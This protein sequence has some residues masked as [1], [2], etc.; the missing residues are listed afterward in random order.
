MIINDEKGLPPNLIPV[1]RPPITP[2]VPPLNNQGPG[3][4]FAGA[5]PSTLQ[6]DSVFVR[7]QYPNSAGVP[8]FP[9]VPLSPANAV[10]NSAV[11]SATKQISDEAGE[12]AIL[13]DTANQNALKAL[14]ATFQGAWSN[15]IDYAQGALVD[16]NGVIWVSLQPY[17]SGHEPDLTSGVWWNSTGGTSTFEGDWNSATTYQVGNQVIDV[18]GGGGYY[19][20]LLANTNKQP[21]ANPT[22]W[23]LITAGNLNSY[24]GNYSGATSYT[25][26]E[27]V[28]YQGSLWICIAATSG[29]APSTISSFWTLLGSNGLF[30]GP[31]SS[32]TS[33]TQNMIV[34][35]QNNLWQAT[36]AS[37]NQTPTQGSSTYWILTGPAT[38]DN[39]EN[40]EIYIKGVGV[41]TA[42]SL[43]IQNSNFEASATVL[44][45]PGWVAYDGGTIG[46]ITSGQQSGTQSVSL[47]PNTLA[48]YVTTQQYSCQPGDQ[49]LVGGYCKT[50][51]TAVAEIAILFFT[52][53]GS[54]IAVSGANFGSPISWTFGSGTPIAPANAVYFQVA[55]RLQQASAGTAY[56]D[57]IFCYYLYPSSTLLNPQ[58]SIPPI[59]TPN[60][61]L[62]IAW[63]ATVVTSAPLLNITWSAFNIYYP[64]GL[65]ISV[66]AN[67]GYTTPS[68][69]SLTTVS[70]GSLALR[71]RYVRI[72]FIREG[73]I[74]AIGPETSIS[75]AASHLLQVTSPSAVAGYDGWMPIAAA[76]TLTESFINNSTFGSGGIGGITPIAFGTN[77][78]EPTAGLTT[79]GD[80]ISE[81]LATA[82]STGTGLFV[83]GNTAN[84]TTYSIYPAYNPTDGNLIFP[85]GILSS[86]GDAA[87][88]ALMW[89]DGNIP[90]Q[91][92]YAQT[93]SP[94][95]GGS[96]SG[97]G[98]G[99]RGVL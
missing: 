56:F 21:S 71:T 19:I 23:Q 72:C 70:G 37:T 10:Q 83:M 61:P 12:A 50:D 58:G 24:E 80:T 85:N 32:S 88:A 86:A 1:D 87:S 22:D 69:P 76:N 6:H 30:M 38:L 7:T 11:L 64:D 17:N 94:S 55:I 57:N 73:A 18:A 79:N 5:I 16:Y 13:A 20:A 78:T 89:A 43:T 33:Y 90:L 53:T 98:G 8:S 97:S 93:T 4:F 31:W 99:G 45:P 14:A 59:V 46:Y 81:Y 47:G 67:T 95:A 52:G 42:T 77:W 29:N 28:S 27:T 51:G 3:D 75:V 44:P 92:G 65:T 39:L 60:A 15:L 74:L 66:P 25:I 62:S 35:Y 68:T 40:G 26:G 49:F 84:S 2:G 91:A 54:L 63:K 96:S 9:L 36:Q 82:S 34:A 41:E 48:S